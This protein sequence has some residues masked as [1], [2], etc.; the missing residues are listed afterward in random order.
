MNQIENELSE[1]RHTATNTLVVYMEQIEEAF[2][3]AGI[4][5]PLSSNEKG[6][7]SMSWSTD[8]EDVGG[9]VNLYGLDS[10]PGGLSCTNINTGFSVLRNY[11]QW[12]SNYS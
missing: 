12:F 2:R 3:S 9:A 10:Y 5:V 1:T 7:R 8:Y 6:E 4:I 11:F